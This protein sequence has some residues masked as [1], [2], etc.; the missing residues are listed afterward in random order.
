MPFS[1]AQVTALAYHAP[2][3]TSVKALLPV[4]RRTSR[5]VKV[6]VAGLGNSSFVSDAFGADAV[7]ALRRLDRDGSFLTVL[8]EVRAVTGVDSADV[9]AS[10]AGTVKPDLVIA[11]DA[12]NAVELVNR[13][14]ADLRVGI[15]TDDITE[16]DVM[17]HLEFPALFEH[18]FQRIVVGVD[19]TQN[20]ILSHLLNISGLFPARGGR[21][22][23][24]LLPHRPAAGFRRGY[25]YEIRKNTSRA[26]RLL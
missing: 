23:D 15:V 20:R 26:R 10:V 3:A 7:N 8:P 2:S 4:T 22:P 14:H 21:G 24:A 17:I 11:A 9:I 16:G 19:V 5:G 25:L 13:A 6:L 12:R 18:H 1:A